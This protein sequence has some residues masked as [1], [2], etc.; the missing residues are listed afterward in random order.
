MSESLINRSTTADRVGEWVL[1]LVNPVL[2]LDVQ[3]YRSVWP[4]PIIVPNCCLIPLYVTIS[5]KVEFLFKETCFL[6][7]E[8]R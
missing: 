6:N 5:S 8:E 2:N 4:K 3:N 7:V 1:K